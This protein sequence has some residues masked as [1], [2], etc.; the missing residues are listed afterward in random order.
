MALAL[1]ALILGAGRA[2]RGCRCRARQHQH[3]KH[4]DEFHGH[5]SLLHLLARSSAVTSHVHCTREHA[6]RNIDQLLILVDQNASPVL[7]PN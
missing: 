5:S 4:K 1:H 7:S 3:H 6:R 2:A